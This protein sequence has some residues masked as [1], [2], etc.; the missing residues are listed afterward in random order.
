M[1]PEKTRKLQARSGNLM[2]TFA[3]LVFISIG[4]AISAAGWY[5]THRQLDLVE[6]QF[7]GYLADH[8][9]ATGVLPITNGG[10]GC[11]VHAAFCATDVVTRW[12]TPCKIGQFL[13][14]SG[15][16]GWPELTE[17]AP[18]LP[19][20]ML[21]PI[22]WTVATSWSDNVAQLV[23]FTPQRQIVQIDTHGDWLKCF[24][25][26]GHRVAFVVYANGHRVRVPCE[27]TGADAQVQIP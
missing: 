23:T 4:W 6:N 13:T 3:A 5:Q 21:D 17:F 10:P 24:Q 20:R 16:C 25:W 1:T 8:P 18:D 14:A 12:A 15:D 22:E 26:N 19:A 7:R 11:T 9:G 27:T 2:A